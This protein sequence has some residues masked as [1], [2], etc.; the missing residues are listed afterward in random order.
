MRAQHGG[1]RRIAAASVLLVVAALV[2]GTTAT[3][4]GAEA[5]EVPCEGTAVFVDSGVTIKAEQP[6]GEVA[7]ILPEDVVRFEV[8]IAA[9]APSEQVAA[10]GGVDVDLPLGQS[11]NA[12]TWSSQTQ[13]TSVSGEY[14]YTVPVWVPRGPVFAVTA[15]NDFGTAT[16]TVD[17]SIQLEGEPGAYGLAAAA[18]MVLFGVGT[19]AAGIRKRDT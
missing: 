11:W 16:C 14:G 19:A 2:L 18:S 8:S 5:V 12:V 4:A 7:V 3:A 10:I 17:A 13:A 6:A 1:R 15:W 9:D